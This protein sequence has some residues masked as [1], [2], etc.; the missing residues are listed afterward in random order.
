MGHATHDN[1]IEGHV[2]IKNTTKADLNVL[3]KRIDVGYTA[4]TDSN[5]ICWGACF[6]PDVSVALFS[7][8]IPGETTNDKDFV[9]HVYPDQDG[10][11]SSGS[12]TYVFYV[13]FNET[14]SI[15]YTMNFEVTQDFDLDENQNL[16]TLSVFPNPAIGKTQV[17]YKLNNQ[18]ENYF[19]LYSLL[20]TKVFE[21]QLNG[22]EGEFEFNVSEFSQGVYYYALKSKGEVVETKKMVIK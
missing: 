15:V 9:A 10:M 8:K 14:D 1:D 4:L 20:G 17:S 19:E 11:P 7:I 6:N 2:A 18:D 12:I 5:A 3:V 22:R 16:N 21:R 13:E